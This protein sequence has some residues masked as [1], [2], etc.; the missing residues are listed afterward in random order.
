MVHTAHEQE[1]GIGPTVRGHPQGKFVSIAMIKAIHSLIFL[2]MAASILYTLYSGVTGRISRLS[3]ASIAAVLGEGL[4]LLLNNMRCPL[5]DLVEELGSEHGSV[6]DIFLPKW[7][8][9][10]IPVLFTPPFAVGV[11]LIG[12]RRARQQ[13]IVA[14]LS[15]IIAGLF[16]VVP[17]LLRMD[18]PRTRNAKA[19]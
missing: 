19:A 13:P 9:E 10:R 5:T 7:F 12:I 1:R 18:H 8:A 17:W 16:L 11:A 15:T 4:V 2:S 3:G 6:S 14:R